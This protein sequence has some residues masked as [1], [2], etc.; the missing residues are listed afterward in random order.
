LR[1]DVPGVPCQ[2]LNTAGAGD[3]LTGTLLARLALSGFYPSSVA[4]GLPE[5]VEAA[6][7]TCERW[8][9]VD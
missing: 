1:A 3:V 9:A 8:G 2:V 5:A 7:R 6:A 4:A